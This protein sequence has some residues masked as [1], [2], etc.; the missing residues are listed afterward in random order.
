MISSEN[1]NSEEIIK[2]L[3]VCNGLNF[4]KINQDGPAAKILEMFFSGYPKMVGLSYFP[5]LTVLILVRQNIQNVVGLESCPLLEELWVTECHLTKIEGLHHCPQLEKLYLYHNSIAII[6]ALESL[7]KLEVLWLNDNQIETIQGLSTMQNLKEL[8]LAGNLI[9]SIGQCLDPNVELEQLNLSGNKISSFKEL[10]NLAR[11]PNLKDLGLK[12]PQYS[13]NPVCLFCNYATHVVYHIPKLQRLDT[14]DVS[15]KDI[16]DLAES[17]V[18]KKIIYYNMRVKT[19]DRRL[20][21]ELGK[22]KEHKCKEKQIP[23]NRIRVLRFIMKNLECELSELQLSA[24]IQRHVPTSHG[25]DQTQSDMEESGDRLKTLKD[26]TKNYSSQVEQKVCA[27]KERIMFWTRKLDEI[28]IFHEKDIARTNESSDLLVKFLQIELE[29]VGNVRFEEGTPYDSWFKSCYDLILSRFCAWDFKAFG[30]SGVKINRIIRVH[31]RILRLKFEDKLQDYMDNE[32]ICASENYRTML[33]YLF[34]IFDPKFPVEKRE[35]LHVLEDGFKVTERSKLLEQEQDEAVLLS[36][37]LSLCEGSRLEF[38]Q[39]QATTEGTNNADPESFR[40]GKLVIGKVF[41]GRSVQARENLPIKPGNYVMSDSVFSPRKNEKSA[42]LCSLNDEI[43]SSKEHGNCDCSL[44]QCEWFVFDHELVLPE[45]VVEFEYI[46]LEKSPFVSPSRVNFQAEDELHELK[47]DEDIINAEPIVKP[48]PKI[49]SLDEKTVLSVARANIMS[50]ITV[51]NLH[52]NSLSKLKD[53]SKLNGLR[54]LIISFNEFSSLEDVSYLCN[55]EYLDASHNRVITLEGFKS[56]G[57]LKHLDLSW[58]RLTKTREEIHNL[59]KQ[60]THLLSLDIQHNPWHKPALVRKTVTGRLTS[61]THLD[62]VCITEEEV[63]DSLRFFAGSRINQVSLLINSRTDE[64]RPRC[65]SFLP[66]AQILSQISKNCLDPYAEFN[67]SWYSMITSLNFDGQ[68]LPKI[69]NLEKLENLRWASFSNNYLTKI[70]GLEHCVHLEELSLDGNYITKV[71]GLSKLAK[72]RR[73]S[74]NSN[75]LTS[76]DRQV[77]DSLPHL[78]F[79][80]AEN[81]NINS[82]AGLQQ[83][84]ALIELYLSNNKISNNQEVYNLKGLSNLVIVDMYGNLI[85]WKHE[86]YRL[87]VVFHLPALK[88]LDGIAVD[89]AESEN[90]KDVFG[91]RLTSDM[92]A[93]KMGHQNFTELQELNWKTST[94]RSVDLAPAEQFRNVHTVNLENNNLT[95]FSGLIFLPNIKNLNLNHNHIESILPRQKPHNQLTN[96]QI[97]HQKVNSSGYGQQGTSKGCREV[98]F[99]ETLTPIMQTLEVLHLGY[100]GISNLPQLQLS[101]LNHLKSLFLQ[102]NE[103]S[104][105]EALDGLQFL[106]ELV[107]DH[108][109]IKVITDSSFAK[110]NSLVALH[111]EENRLRNLNNLLPLIKLKKLFVGFNKI[112]EMSEVDKLEA[113]PTLIELSVSGNPISRKMFHRQLIVLRLQNLQVLD[114]IPVTMDERARAEMDFMEQQ[115]LSVANS[116]MDMGHPVSNLLLTKPAPLRITNVTLPGGIHHFGGADFHLNNAHEDTIPNEAN[117]YKKSKHHVLGMA[118]NP[119]SIHAEIAFRQLRGGTNLSSSYLTQQSAS[120]RVPHMYPNN[121][122]HDGRLLSNGS[123]RQNRM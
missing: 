46:T 32:D 7:T 115:A 45:Y 23:E 123:L 73:L 95:S 55:L 43:C 29:T 58:N 27:L 110:Q 41:L 26:C 3:C 100:N 18:M 112:Q 108:N 85:S 40:Y 54:R 118:Q 99:G 65:L 10:T 47:L 80:S 71:E 72:L 84:N 66:C 6:E 1:L 34:Y 97:L 121:Q 9:H 87:F 102:G 75:L 106:Q 31:N 93:E 14:Y 44:R 79:L 33:E 111:L 81:N 36:N 98:L 105:V 68:N 83:A 60:A 48:R 11:L 25:C 76:F 49:I 82:L 92:I 15:H 62:G 64:V 104:R 35:L 77:I 42:S 2:E 107:L 39:K 19:I 51:L 74:L 53:I 52:G 38:L 5:N 16:K 117:K 17:T 114:G 69:T 12:D 109:R 67:S 119:R 13:P 24:N 37:S 20:R 61:L 88:A 113:L 103:I 28:Q 120:N 94:I 30:I 101:R 116:A 59:R 91:G 90:A 86:H 8:N 21:E 96:R 122:E 4:E 70:E 22:L 78:H 50:Q 56:L 89:P 63:S 57:K